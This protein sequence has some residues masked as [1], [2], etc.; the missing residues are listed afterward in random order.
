M[1]EVRLNIPKERPSRRKSKTFQS[2]VYIGTCFLLNLGG[3]LDAR[4]LRSLKEAG[5]VSTKIHS[6]NN[7]QNLFETK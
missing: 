3:M 7:N 6:F 5:V 1:N 2:S 4:K